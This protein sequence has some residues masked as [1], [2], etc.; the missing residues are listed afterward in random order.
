MR[1]GI[2]VRPLAEKS[3][4]GVVEYVQNLLLHILAV[5][6]RNEYI[7]FYNSYRRKNPPFLNELQKYPNV[8]L[9]RFYYPNKIL[10][11]CM[12][13]LRRPFLD[14]LLDVPVLFSPNIIFT[15]VSSDC[16]HVLTLHD[17]SFVRHKEFFDRYRRLWHWLVNP[18]R[19]VKEADTIVT[20]SNSS[21][22]DIVS[23][24]QCS[25]T[26]IS[27]IY[28]GI[29]KT[30]F[31][32]KRAGR[33]FVNLQKKYNLPEKY[34]L[35]LATLEPRKNIENAM[36]AYEILRRKN[37]T[38]HKLVIAGSTGWLFDR[39][40]TAMLKSKFRK[41][42]HFVGE[43]EDADRC[44]LYTGAD[45][46]VYPSYYEGF[47]FP[48]LEALKCGTTVVCSYT[49]SLSEVVGSAAL[50]VNPYDPHEIAWAME[51]GLKDEKLKKMLRSEGIK[52]AGKFFWSDTAAEVIRILERAGSG[53]QK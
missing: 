53:A 6:R 33:V 19:L 52:R 23:L 5:D 1:I 11:F 48:P 10:N 37:K 18:R 51:R 3:R 34:I 16:R 26:K 41:D 4:S 36:I 30:F 39:T 7:L 9:R 49:S 31:P 47:G 21:K 28:P 42:I 27:R 44:L 43:V 13:Y 14:R 15:S 32:A 20:V 50:L 25:S 12:W 35:I 29:G 2:D 22:D 45:L 24:Y 38:D 8:F 40:R 17:L 46:F